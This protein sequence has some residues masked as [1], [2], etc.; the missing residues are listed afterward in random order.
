MKFQEL[1][2]FWELG[3]EKNMCSKRGKTIFARILF[4]SFC[5]PFFLEGVKVQSGSF[6]SSK[7]Q[8]SNQRIGTE[9]CF[10]RVSF[11]LKKPV[12]SR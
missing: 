4:A 9:H 11:L 1:A 6:R 10:F 2:F 5:L 8:S 7:F 3:E 12:L